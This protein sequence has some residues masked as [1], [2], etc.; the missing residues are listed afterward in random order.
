MVNPF[1]K[2]I[3]QTK[4]AI[5]LLWNSQINLSHSNL[6]SLNLWNIKK[7]KHIKSSQ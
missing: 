6:F 7:Y 3:Q 5:N 2:Y 1:L 4:S